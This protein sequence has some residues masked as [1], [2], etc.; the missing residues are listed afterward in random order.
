MAAQAPIRQPNPAPAAP[1]KRLALAADIFAR[2]VVSTPANTVTLASQAQ[3]ALE[4]ADAF[5]AI[6]K[7]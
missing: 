7:E 1:G 5:L 4:A 6:A 3:R 2:L